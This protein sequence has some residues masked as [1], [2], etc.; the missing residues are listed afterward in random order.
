MHTAVEKGAERVGRPDAHGTDPLLGPDPVIDCVI[1]LNRRDYLQPGEAIEIFCCNML[2]VLDAKAMITCPT[3]FRDLLEH[4]EDHGNCAVA[5][6][7]N[8]ELQ[9]C[10]VSA[11]QTL[12]HLLGRLHLVREQSARLWRVRV[13]LEKI[14]SCRAE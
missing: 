14:R 9:S 11:L 10:T 8:A 5:N 2:R 13:R 12:Q 1:R 6:G 3:A 7:M 4:I